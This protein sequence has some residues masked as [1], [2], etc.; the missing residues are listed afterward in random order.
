[1]G[2][3]ASFDPDAAPVSRRDEALQEAAF[4]IYWRFIR[5]DEAAARQR[6]A[7]LKPTQLENWTADA[8]VAFRVFERF[9][10]G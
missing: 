1:M 5:G 8:E 7:K 10:R 4:A 3:I 6:F 9:R 2:M